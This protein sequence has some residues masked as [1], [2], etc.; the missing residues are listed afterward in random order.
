MKLYITLFSTTI[1]LIMLT[2]LQLCLF[3]YQ[4]HSQFNPALIAYIYILMTNCSITLLTILACMLDMITYLITGI[5]GINILFLVPMSWF[6]LK[7]KDDMYNKIII[8]CCFIFVY[9]IFYN[10]VLKYS[11]NYPIHF[12]DILVACIQNCFMFLIVWAISKQPFHD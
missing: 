9:A 12:G 2:S 11:I 8:P 5:F 3:S 6:A 10:I 4:A 7:I 1:I